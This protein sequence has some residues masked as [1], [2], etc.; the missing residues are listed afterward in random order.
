MCWRGWRREIFNVLRGLLVVQTTQAVVVTRETHALISQIL[1]WDLLDAVPEELLVRGPSQVAV[2]S[3][4][5]VLLTW[6][7]GAVYQDLFAQ[8]LD[9]SLS[10][11]M[12]LF[13]Y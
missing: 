1:D 3:I 2:P 13:K 5:G 6:E 7:G 12:L 10:T 4:M 11:T 8:A 9:V